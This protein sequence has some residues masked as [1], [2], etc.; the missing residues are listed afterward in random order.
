MS[1]RVR[2]ALSATAAAAPAASTVHPRLITSATVTG[3]KRMP[4]HV[5]PVRPTVNQLRRLNLLSCRQRC[6]GGWRS[7]PVSVLAM[8]ASPGDFVARQVRVV[9]GA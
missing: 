3:E 1:V 2:T 6:A 7:L 8:T 9:R 5:Q 4:G